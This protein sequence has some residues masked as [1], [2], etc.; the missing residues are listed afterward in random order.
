MKYVKS[1]SEAGEPF[2]VLS[3]GTEVENSLSD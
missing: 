3:C 1:F 2:S